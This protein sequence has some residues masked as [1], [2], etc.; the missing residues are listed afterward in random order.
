MPT[1]NK[2]TTLIDMEI[3]FSTYFLLSRPLTRTNRNV[4]D[5]LMK[6][7]ISIKLSDFTNKIASALVTE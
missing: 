6:K 5:E 4:C 2:K 7:D 3:E 1:K